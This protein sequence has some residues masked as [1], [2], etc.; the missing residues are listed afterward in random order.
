MAAKIFFVEP[1]REA[2]A[3]FLSLLAGT[4]YTV[5]PEVTTC[6]QAV[7]CYLRLKPVLVVLPMAS[8]TI[9][10]IQALKAIK[11]GDPDARVV[12]TYDVKSTHLVEEALREGALEV[13][14]RP[15]GKHHVVERLA[16]AEV[17]VRAP[18]HTQPLAV[19]PKPVVIEWKPAKGF[20]ARWHES[21]TKRIGIS[22]LDFRSDTCPA[23]GLAVLLRIHI[24]GSAAME[25]PANVIRIVE[26]PGTKSFDVSLSYQAASA[27]DKDRLLHMIGQLVAHG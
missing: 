7:S 11:R 1:D 12:L 22:G 23:L 14:K 27:E 21:S 17:A 20:L 8:P 24:P 5:V 18:R 6:E 13:I 9:G 3:E 16:L 2:R 26:D 10:G 4:K 15:F 19:L 25:L